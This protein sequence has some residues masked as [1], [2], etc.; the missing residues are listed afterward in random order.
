MISPRIAWLLSTVLA[1]TAALSCGASAPARF[2]TL[3]S[4]ATAD[5]LPPASYGVAI[6]MVSVPAAVD[7]PQLVVQVA[8]N[9]VEIDEFNRWAAP[10]GES[11]AGAVATDLAVLL[12][13][14]NVATGLRASFDPSYRVTIDVQRFDSGP[15]EG[16][17]IDAV[18]A[19]SR[20]TG[21]DVRSGRTIAHESVQSE[22]VD[23]LVAAHSR[24]LTQL[25]KDIAAA[26]RA[27]AKPAR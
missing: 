7:R 21:D 16:V 2:Y 9:R 27:S 19:V 22:S 15:G 18:W 14:P 17:T 20:T 3:D 11:I 26:I 8:P 13:T 12:G 1:A 10:L 24:A 23:A 25:S 6:A 4:R 5:G